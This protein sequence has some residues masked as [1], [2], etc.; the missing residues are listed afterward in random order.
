M[1]VLR[2]S[3]FFSG[4][5]QVWIL[6]S[7][8]DWSDPVSPQPTTLWPMISSIESYMII[9]THHIF[10][11]TSR[12]VLVPKQLSATAYPSWHGKLTII[13][14]VLICRPLLDLQKSVEIFLFFP[15]C[16]FPDCST[17]TPL[18]PQNHF[19]SV[20]R[21]KCLCISSISGYPGF[22]VRE[23]NAHASVCLIYW[24]VGRDQQPF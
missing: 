15:W 11:V 5:L 14:P 23:T 20:Q 22:F 8:A 1:L 24:P 9:N 4:K 7:S 16:F 6:N 19:T 17:V 3:S 10:I 13:C 21:D 12:P 18:L 2:Q